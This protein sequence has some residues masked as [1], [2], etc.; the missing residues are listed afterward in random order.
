MSDTLL[1]SGYKIMNL[2]VRGRRGNIVQA[3]PA[4]EYDFVPSILE[5][6]VSLVPRFEFDLWLTYRFIFSF[7]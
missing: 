4:V 3:Y 6:N 5:L 2:N 7:F 1:G